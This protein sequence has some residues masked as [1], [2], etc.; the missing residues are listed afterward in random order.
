MKRGRSMRYVVGLVVGAVLLGH[1]APAA[2]QQTIS[3]GTI[4]GVVRDDK[5]LPVPGATVEARNEDTSRVQATVS[6][7][8]G[9]FNVPAL[10]LGRYT[11]KVSLTGFRTVEKTGIQLRSGEVYNA[12]QIV[13]TVG[14]VAETITVT[15]E[16][17]GVETA[18]AV[19][20]AVIEAGTLESLV[21]RG[22][23]PVRLLNAL[24]GVDPSLGGNISGGT[25]GTGLP[26]MQGTA[27]INTYVA[28]DGIGSA[29]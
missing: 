18:T 13:L 3:T 25:I 7:S 29:D 10:V 5:N 27:G 28:I 21:S 23:D 20:T 12:G 17:A 2:A 8:T 22:R 1:V 14:G 15:A 16:A 24:P 19:R 11:L 4:T 26:S 6:N 9:T